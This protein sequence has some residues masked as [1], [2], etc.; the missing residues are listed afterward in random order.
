MNEEMD[1]LNIIDITDE[2]EWKPYN[3]S[4]RS[5]DD[6]FSMIITTVKDGIDEWLLSHHDRR[7]C[8]IHM[9]KPK[10]RLTPEYL[11]QIC[12]CSIET[13]RKTIEATTCRHHR[14]T[15]KGPTKRYRPSRNF[16]RYRQIRL[17]AGEF[18][19]DTM[20]FKVRSIIGHT[21]AQIYGNK[22][23][24][25]RAYPLEKHDKQFLGD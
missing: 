11:A 22:F 6:H 4:Y 17:P 16:M 12:K 24:Y 10:D 19:T 8:A 23:G 20:L 25:I 3:E 13:A 1:N 7:L 21:C 2:H 5:N 18:Y 15:V 9:S 14:N